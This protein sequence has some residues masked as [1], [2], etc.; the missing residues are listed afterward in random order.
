M[1][2]CSRSRAKTGFAPE[3]DQR[4]AKVNTGNKTRTL[5]NLTPGCLYLLDT[6]NV[7]KHSVYLVQTLKLKPT[8][9]CFCCLRHSI[10]LWTTLTRWMKEK[11]KDG[12][13]IQKE[14][15][16]ADLDEIQIEEFKHNCSYCHHGSNGKC[17]PHVEK[18]WQM[19]INRQMLQR[20]G[21]K[22][23]DITY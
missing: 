17:E 12:L 8:C 6:L 1:G 16:K 2:G 18:Y 9:W 4:K 19:V 15:Q 20:N 3:Q 13:K 23:W 10:R 5:E 11:R 7:A 14:H 21:R 22:H